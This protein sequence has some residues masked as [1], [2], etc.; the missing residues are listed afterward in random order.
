MTHASGHRLCALSARAAVRRLLTEKRSLVGTH[1]DDQ[2]ETPC[3]TGAS[4][5]IHDLIDLG[6]R[7]SS[8]EGLGAVGRDG[9]TLRITL[10]NA[11]NV[12]GNA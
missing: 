4:G 12:A 6:R 5:R 7:W 1:V 9:F 8:R 3:I 11:E 2:H 10:V